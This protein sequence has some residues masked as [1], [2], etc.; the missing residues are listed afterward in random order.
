M[1]LSPEGGENRALADQSLQQEGEPDPLNLLIWP[2]PNL[3]V[4]GVAVFW[5]VL[6]AK[7]GGSFP[8]CADPKNG[9]TASPAKLDLP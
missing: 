2:A 6:H 1:L 7:D 9:K 4:G 8:Y 5:G 3:G